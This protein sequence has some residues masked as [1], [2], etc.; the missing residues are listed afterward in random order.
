MEQVPADEMRRSV[1]SAMPDLHP[2]YERSFI[3]RKVLSVVRH[4]SVSTENT[5]SN[6]EDLSL[7]FISL[8]VLLALQAR[9]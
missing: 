9:L 5:F 7:F 4:S 6:P 1:F 8:L 3:P 2:R